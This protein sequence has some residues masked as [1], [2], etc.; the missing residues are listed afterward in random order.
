ML[1]LQL[2][3]GLFLLILG[4][5]ALVRGAS[6][7]ASSI[8]LSSL[9]VGLTVV[10]FGTSSPELAV[11]VQAAVDGQVGLAVGNVV[12]SNTFNVR[13]ILGISAVILPLSITNRIVRFDVPV[14][15]AVTGLA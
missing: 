14:M 7:L 1:V 13:L 5:E 15:I 6:R 3:T 9:L 10:A 8:G 2:V 11:T 4:A 12:G